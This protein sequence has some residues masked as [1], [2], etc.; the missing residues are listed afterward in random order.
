MLGDAIVL[1]LRFPNTQP[2]TS[3]HSFPNNQPH[4]YVH[5]FPNSQPY[6]SVHWFPNS[7]QY[8]SVFNQKQVR[9]SSVE[10]TGGCS[11][12]LSSFTMHNQTMPPPCST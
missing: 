7:H 11:S 8:T 12:I 1:L 3:V 10:A 4:T 2:H 6:T 5:R 9:E